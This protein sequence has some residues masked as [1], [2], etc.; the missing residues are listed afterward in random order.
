MTAKNTDT[1]VKCADCA[2]CKRRAGG[3]ESIITLTG[4]SES[5]ARQQQRDCEEISDSSTRLETEANTE[6]G[7]EV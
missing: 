6:T 1:S 5:E 7:D 4:L 2:G 3:G